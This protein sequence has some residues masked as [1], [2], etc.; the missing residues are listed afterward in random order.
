MSQRKS[1]AG[2]SLAG[3]A[4]VFILSGCSSSGTR[5]NLAIVQGVVYYQ[6]KPLS[7]GTIHF[8]RP[9]KKK[10]TFFIRGDGTYGGEVPFGSARVAIE[11]DSVKYY[12]RETMLKMW[13]EK[14]GY[15]ALTEHQKNPKL[16]GITAPKLV[17]VK[18][19]DHYS[20]PDRSNLSC[21]I[22]E[23]VQDVDFYLK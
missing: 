16:P 3:L 9:D 2:L 11:T 19:P 18:I 5:P 20:D 15:E 22:E 6:D 8:V 17:Y 10:T 13:Q 4:S 7:G 14:S 1:L 12:D 21:E 23:G